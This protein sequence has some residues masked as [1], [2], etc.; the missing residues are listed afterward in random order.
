MWYDSKEGLLDHV[1]T[2]EG[3][4]AIIEERHQASYQRK[5]RMKEFCLL[6]TYMLDSCGNCGTITGFVP[7]REIANLPLVMTYEE[8]WEQIRVY[9]LKLYPDVLTSEEMHAEDFD[10][11]NNKRPFPTSVSYHYEASVPPHNK[12][13]PICSRGWTTDNCWDT[14]VRGENKIARIREEFHCLVGK[15]IANLRVKLAERK[16][17][18]CYIHTKGQPF[19]R[20]DRYIDLTPNPKYL[21]LKVNERGW[22][23]DKTIT[24]PEFY[25]L[26]EGDE[27]SYYEQRWLHKEC[28]RIS[29]ERATHDE[30][31]SVVQK[32]G[33]NATILHKQPNK[34]CQC[35]LCAPW[36]VVESPLTPVVRGLTIGWRKRVINISFVHPR[37]NFVEL[38]PKEDVTKGD[39]FIHAWGYD[40]A[41]EYLRKV[42]ETLKSETLA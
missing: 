2:L 13:C 19:L 11:P 9:D 7:R 6:G 25:V 21:S 16:D 26:Q 4:N 40:K 20:N 33:M 27:I 37:I 18:C 38:F 28:N 36:F 35:E 22:V 42:F 17:S 3:L 30:F 15:T 31:L 12:V 8:L 34:Y 41:E 10:W 5:E 14:F 23:D 29:R 39:D 24:D 32:A 1:K